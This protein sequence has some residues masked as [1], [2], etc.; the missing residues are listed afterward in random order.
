MKDESNTAERINRMNQLKR[1]LKSSI[2]EPNL[3]L[4]SLQNNTLCVIADM[5]NAPLTCLDLWIK[6]GSVYEKPG[7]EGIAHFLEHMV[8][9]GGHNLKEGDFDRKIEAFGGSSNAAT[10]FDDVHFHVLV[11]PETVRYAIDLLLDLVLAPTLNPESFEIEKEVVLEEIAQNND[12]PE[13]QI[14][15]QLL[16]S[17]WGK[18]AYGRPILGYEKSLRGM[19]PNLMKSFH[20][21]L[22]KGIN[23]TISIAGVIPKDI[24]KTINESRLSSIQAG[25]RRVKIQPHNPSLDF[26]TGHKEIK[27]KRLESSRLTM[28]WPIPEAKEQLQIMGSDIATSILCEGRRSRLISHLREELQIVESIEMD[29]TTLEEGGLII[30]EACCMENQLNRV[31]KEIH[32]TLKEINLKPPTDQEIKRAC[33]LIKNNLCFSL[34]LTSNVA[35]IAGSQVT[36][37]RHQP[38]L[39]QLDYIDYWTTNKLISEIFSKIQP[40]KGTTLIARP[41]K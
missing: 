12:L 9:K 29:V 40:D 37:D 7:E 26:K 20:E 1:T 4:W 39:A 27:V 24:E 23:C 41:Q 32:K 10:G 16:Q 34:E 19:T 21:R 11:P 30:L 25:G 13:E 14:F 3:T 6:A 31:E 8:F 18:H 2:Q 36:W 28:A 38:L 33:Q 17:C 5:P 35:A 22:Y 15:Q